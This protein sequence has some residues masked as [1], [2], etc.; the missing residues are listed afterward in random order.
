M[1]SAD[2]FARELRAQLKKNVAAQGSVDTVINSGELYRSLGGYPGSTHGM[3]A[4][5]TRGNNPRI[6]D[7]TNRASPHKY[8]QF[9]C[10]SRLGSWPK[11][12]MLIRLDHA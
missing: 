7:F 4:C 9:P 2:H 1:V 11:G 12:L 8:R 3:P 6:C 5:E 10:F